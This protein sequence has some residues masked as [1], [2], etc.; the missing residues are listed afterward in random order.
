MP[1]VSRALIE[2]LHDAGIGVEIA[3]VGTGMSSLQA[4]H[5][6]P[7]QALKIDRAFIH[8][9]GTDPRTAKLVQMI[10]DIGETLGFDVVAE[11]VETADQAAALDQCGCLLAQGFYFARPME[12]DALRAALAAA[13]GPAA[14]H[15]AGGTP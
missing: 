8:D 1:E 2:R 9:L 7:I 5:L 12:G 14:S 3:G 15:P 13:P 4:L 11:G 6:L 10:V